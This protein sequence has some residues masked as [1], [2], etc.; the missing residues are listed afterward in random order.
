VLMSVCCGVS[1]SLCCSELH[2]CC[3]ALVRVVMCWFVIQVVVC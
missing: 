1:S 2:M 3:N